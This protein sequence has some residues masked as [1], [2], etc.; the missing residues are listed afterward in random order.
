MSVATTAAILVDFRFI[1]CSGCKV[2]VH[3]E[4]AKEC[5]VC[6]CTFDR[7]S[8]NHVGLAKDLQAKREAAGIPTR[9]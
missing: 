1:C 6:G 2:A 4:L 3:D 7:V 9:I 8:S 5:P